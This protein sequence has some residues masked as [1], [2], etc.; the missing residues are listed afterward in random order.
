MIHRD[1]PSDKTS[2][3]EK[4]LPVIKSSP[5]VIVRCPTAILSPHMKLKYNH[6][7]PLQKQSHFCWG[8]DGLVVK[9]PD[10]K[11]LG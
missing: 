2:D 10:L 7:K 1:S 8:G 4:K 6:V 3:K 9:T 11:T 5:S